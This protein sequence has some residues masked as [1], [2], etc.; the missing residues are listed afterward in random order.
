MINIP[1]HIVSVEVDDTIGQAN[2]VVVCHQ[3]PQTVF[4]GHIQLAKRMPFND[5]TFMKFIAH[6][7]ATCGYNDDEVPPKKEVLI[8][9]C[10]KWKHDETMEYDVVGTIKF[11][12]N[13]KKNGLFCFN[14]Q[15]LGTSSYLITLMVWC[16]DGQWC[17]KEMELS[18]YKEFTGDEYT[19]S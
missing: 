16:S 1:H 13:F 12:N 14:L 9:F 15:E 8:G 17:G 11:S 2:Y 4:Q 6:V 7:N 10:S 19:P 5:N 18:S 3:P